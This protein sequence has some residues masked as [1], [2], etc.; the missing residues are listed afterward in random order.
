[1]RI[2]F[3]SG[4]PKDF[5]YFR[6]SITKAVPE[7]LSSAPPYTLPW[8]STPTWSKCED[9]TIGGDT[10]SFPCIKPATLFNFLFSM[11]LI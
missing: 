6:N 3:L 7:A 11:I 9:I 2:I 10:G 4:L 5:K 1:M 8:R